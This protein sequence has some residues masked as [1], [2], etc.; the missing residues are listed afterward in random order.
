M[1]LVLGAMGNLAPKLLQLLQSE[2]ELPKDVR[3]KVE[4]VTV[5]LDAIQAALRKVATVPLDQL[6]EQVKVWARHVKD[7]SYDMEDLLDTLLLRVE[8]GMSV[9]LSRLKQVTEKM[10][11][12]FRKS[13]VRRD[14][15]VTLDDIK[16]QLQHLV[17]T[18]DRYRITD[19]VAYR[20]PATTVDPRLSAFHTNASQLVGINKPRDELIE[21]LFRWEDD[22]YEMKIISIVGFGGLGKT[23]L[24]KAVYD[25]VYHKFECGAFVQVGRNPDLKKVLRDVLIDVMKTIDDHDKLFILDVRQLIN[26][27]HRFLEG[28]RYILPT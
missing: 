22:S 4:F 11:G 14:I 13:M 9:N 24:A 23:T 8:G 12:L 3:R 7:A 5:E 21:M 18:R 25:R 16:K 6:D 26:L 20:A 17:D 2:Y 19:T 10:G 27:L 1:A 15:I 28:K